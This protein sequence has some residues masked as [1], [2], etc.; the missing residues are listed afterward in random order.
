VL[1]AGGRCGAADDLQQPLFAVG[2]RLGP[3]CLY[4]QVDRF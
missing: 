1:A 3:E 2:V 4:G